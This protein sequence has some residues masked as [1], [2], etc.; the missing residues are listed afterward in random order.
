MWDP[1]RS[2]LN[3]MTRKTKECQSCRVK[4]AWACEDT[5]SRRTFRKT[6]LTL[7]YPCGRRL[8]LRYTPN[9]YSTLA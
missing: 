9:S 7:F 8:H 6:D 2:L 5:A 4:R 1:W 3:G